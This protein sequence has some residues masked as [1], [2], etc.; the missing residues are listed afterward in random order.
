MERKNHHKKHKRDSSLSL[1]LSSCSSSCSSSDK[2]KKQKKKHFPKNGIIRTG[3]TI[4]LTIK[5]SAAIGGTAAISS[6]VHQSVN[7]FF[8]NHV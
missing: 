6:I 8:I 5:D 3:Y 7:H 1:S 4:I 2:E